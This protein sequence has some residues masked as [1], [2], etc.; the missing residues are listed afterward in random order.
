MLIFSLCVSA[1]FAGLMRE[2]TREQL[3]IGA[4]MFGGDGGCRTR[5]RLV[6]VSVSYLGLAPTLHRS[7]FL[8]FWAPVIAYM[9]MCLC[10]RRFRP[11]RLRP[12][13][14]TYYDVHIWRP[15]PGSAC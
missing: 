3:I 9:A 14:L 4:K 1:V 11:C 13:G 5:A 6:D 15:T 8:S 2:E 12:A 7:P 10:C